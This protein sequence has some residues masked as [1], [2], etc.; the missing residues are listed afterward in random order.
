MKTTSEQY[1]KTVNNVMA[2]VMLVFALSSA[3][4]ISTAIERLENVGI[5]PVARSVLLP[6][7]AYLTFLEKLVK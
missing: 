1:K 5:R 7:S 6:S 3:F 4:S 2:G